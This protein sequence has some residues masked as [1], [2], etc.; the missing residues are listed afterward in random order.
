MIDRHDENRDRDR[1]RFDFQTD[2][3]GR[4]D[5]VGD[6]R[7]RPHRS[8]TAAAPSSR[9]RSSDRMS[10]RFSG[11]A[12]GSEAGPSGNRYSTLCLLGGFHI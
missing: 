6:E 2:G 12:R 11:G 8:N 4:D 5:N 9:G 1:V 10:D 3:S 7:R